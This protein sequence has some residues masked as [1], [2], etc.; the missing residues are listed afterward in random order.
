MGTSESHGIYKHGW[1]ARSAWLKRSF[2]VAVDRLTKAQSS[3]LSLATATTEAVVDSVPE[4]LA[5]GRWAPHYEQEKL[6]KNK[7][8][9]S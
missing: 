4:E 5:E 8:P 6:A 2:A 7:R 1:S 9:N 3:S